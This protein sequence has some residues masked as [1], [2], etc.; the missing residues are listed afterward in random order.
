MSAG[1][2]GEALQELTARMGERDSLTLSHGFGRWR[3]RIGHPV[4]PTVAL[5]NEDLGT[6]L[7][8]AVE[9]MPEPE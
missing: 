9:N 6:L 4:S 5:E 3:L 7:R 1:E 8:R 2:L